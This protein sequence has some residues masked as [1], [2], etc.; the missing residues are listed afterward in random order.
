MDRNGL[1]TRWTH[2]RILL[3]LQAPT[4]LQR[5]SASPKLSTTQSF[6]SVK[7]LL[8]S[9]STALNLKICRLNQ[10]GFYNITERASKAEDAPKSY[11]YIYECRW[12]FPP[13]NVSLNEIECSN[14]G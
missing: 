5:H 1:S 8:C 3:Q 12:V 6:S 10:V 7:E 4:V 2:N 13:S 9:G 14:L 11:N